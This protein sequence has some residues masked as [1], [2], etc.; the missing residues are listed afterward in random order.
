M[1]NLLYQ[2]CFTYLF[3][4]HQFVKMCQSCKQDMLINETYY[5]H[6][7][8]IFFS[9][10]FSNRILPKKINIRVEHIKH[11]NCRLDFLKR[12]KKNEALKREAKE[13]G[14]KANTK[15]YVSGFYVL[16]LS[17]LPI[18]FYCIITVPKHCKINQSD[19]LFSSVGD[20]DL[21]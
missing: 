10:L 1:W 18:T 7:M 17:M 5:A 9:L 6:C 21:P 15:R 19:A 20:H 12:V 16:K 14:I 3:L 13:K 4:F 8:S 2:R 11:S